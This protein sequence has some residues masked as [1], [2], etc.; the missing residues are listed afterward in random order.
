MT[1]RLKLTMV[2]VLVLVPLALGASARRG[3][4]APQQ[5]Q[6]SPAASAPGQQSQ[7]QMQDMMKMHEQMMGEMKAASARLDE[8]ASKMNAATGS[9]RV[10]AT[11]AVVNE[12]VRQHK[13]MVD[14]M[15]QMAEHM[16]GGRGMKMDK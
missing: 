14:H 15:G 4:A 13:A 6:P 7:P 11:V 16:M 9:A 2:I 8:L 1:N 10:D 5:A 3:A 12:L